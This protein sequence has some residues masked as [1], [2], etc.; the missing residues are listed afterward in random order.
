MSDFIV[1][2]GAEGFF[3]A[4]LAKVTADRVKH[5]TITGAALA[6]RVSAFY[7]TQDEAE[8]AEPLKC[9]DGPEGCAGPVEW[10]TTPDR[11][12]GKH[13]QRCEGH[14]DKRMESVERNLEFQ[15]PSAPSWFDPAYAGERW[16]E[17]D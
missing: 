6:N 9:I 4:S 17:D 3:L 8:K 11:T 10:R 16:D 2:K 12:D 15:S 7:G 14:F 13:F 1:Y 5:G